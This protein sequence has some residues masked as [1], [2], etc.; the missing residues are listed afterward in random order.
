MHK[1]CSQNS[2]VFANYAGRGISVCEEWQT[3][4]PFRD[5]IESVVGLPDLSSGTR[6][7]LDRIDND[8][9]YA[10]GNI[11]WTTYKENLRNRRSSVFVEYKGERV[12]AIALTERLGIPYLLFMDRVRKQKWSVERAVD[13]PVVTQYRR[14][15]AT[16]SHDMFFTFRGQSKS[17][18]EW[19]KELAFD[20]PHVRRRL[21][22]GW[23][24][25]RA[26]TAES[27]RGASVRTTKHLISQ[28]A[29][30]CERS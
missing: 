13:T 9:G 12:L 26:V 28:L 14:L 1:R 25:E 2:P 23:D 8:A 6:W 30:S 22:A 3:F 21:N 4:E 7:T 20:I 24:F 18:A 17:L 19:A 16:S 10:P 29:Q 5:Y 11:R 27:N 15:S